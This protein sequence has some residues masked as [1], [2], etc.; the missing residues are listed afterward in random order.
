MTSLI[1]HQTVSPTFYNK[2]AP[3]RV[4]MEIVGNPSLTSPPE[5]VNEAGYDSVRTWQPQMNISIPGSGSS[6]LQK[7]CRQPATSTTRKL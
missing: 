3:M 4:I 7:R 6:A 1:S 5:M 2:I